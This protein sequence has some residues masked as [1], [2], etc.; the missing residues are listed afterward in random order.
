MTFVP[1]PS[2]TVPPLRYL[3]ATDVSAAMPTLEER[4]ALADRI[5][6]ALVADAEV[7]PKIGVHP[8]P[9][10]SFAH[11]MPAFL[12]GAEP[13]GSGDALGIKWVTG[14]GTNNARGLAAINALVVLND[15]SSGLTLAILDGGPIT[16][17]RTAA[18]SGIAIRAFAP[19]ALDEP[20]RAALI[21]A[22]TQ[23]RSHLPVLGH[24]LPGVQLAIFD[25]HLDRAERLAQ[26]ARETA[27]IGSATASTTAQA[28]VREAGVVLTAASF[29]PVRQVMTNDWLQPN[30][31]VVAVDYATY[32]SAQVARTADL[33]LVDER[34]QFL[35]NRAAG[36]FDDYPDPAATIGEALMAALPRPPGRVVVSHLG[37]G[38]ADVIFGRA[39][40][41]E[42]ERRGLGTMLERPPQ[43]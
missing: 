16:A 31:L 15:P 2:P 20:V 3:S 30:A 41:A 11:A 17:E 33:F 25:R 18:I 7:P 34:E 4:L 1:G 8:R 28:A 14:F 10:G 32:C 23:G 35:A 43:P 29:G 36:V 12:S 39:I 42:A 26:L 13:D 38:L 37:V 19:A 21:G 9:E 27:G 24:L 22:G 40:L 6:R 5:M